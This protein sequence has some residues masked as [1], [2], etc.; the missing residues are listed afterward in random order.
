MRTSDLLSTCIRNLMRRKFRTFL[1]ITGVVI[2]TTSIIMMISL[3][4]GISRQQEEQLKQWGDLTIIQVYYNGGDSSATSLDDDAIKSILAIKGVDVA[5]PFLRLQMNYSQPELYA[6]KTFVYRAYPDIIG[7]YPDALEK[8]GY[9]MDK[10]ESLPEGKTKNLKAVFGGAAAYSFEDTRKKFNNRRSNW[11]DENGNIQEPFFEP[12]GESY[13]LELPPSTDNTGGK[14][15]EYE[16][17]VVGLLVGERNKDESMYSIF[18]PIEDM[19]RLQAEYNKENNI[20]TD[21]NKKDA[22]NNIKVK[23][24]N[25]KEIPE[26][27]QKIKDMGFG[28][29]SMETERQE[30]LKSL[31]STQ[32]LLGG[33]GGITLLVSAISITNTMIMSVYERTREIGVMKVLG[34]LV[35]NIRAIFLLEAGF[36]GFF[37]GIAGIGL[38][39]LLSLLLNAFGG[40]L[41]SGGGG[42][43]FGGGIFGRFGRY[44]ET[45]ASISVI[46]AWL[47]LLGLAFATF[48]GLAAGFYPAN[49]AVKIS[50]MEAIKQE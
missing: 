43:M 20:K 30:M 41:T 31:L 13:K 49:R 14:K 17:D 8:I 37:G 4:L 16:L 32:I 11:P 26:I 46:P 48:I 3:A 9:S 24:L 5:T 18:I 22:Y 44:G 29:W 7:I 50:A 23:V 45:S 15:L 6:G 19:K 39:F 34:C 27:E 42:G 38:S 40:A 36:I 2:G 28:T 35:G 21:R 1:T 12:V 33:V 47:V 10:G 25:L